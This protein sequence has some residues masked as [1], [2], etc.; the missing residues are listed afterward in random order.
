MTKKKPTK[1]RVIKW[2]ENPKIV[3]DA[4]STWW[5]IIMGLVGFTLLTA[6]KGIEFAFFVG[7]YAIS[8]VIILVII[9]HGF[10]YYIVE[11]KHLKFLRNVLDEP[12][13]QRRDYD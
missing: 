2:I 10:K 4:F 8:T 9:V 5:S 1:T 12:P 6:F 7:L 13:R 3:E 11:K